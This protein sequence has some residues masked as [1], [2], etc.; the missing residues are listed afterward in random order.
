MAVFLISCDLRNPVF[1]YE[2]LYQALKAVKAEHIQNSVWRVNT[3]STAEIV[4]EYLWRH[5][6]SKRDRLFVVPFDKSQ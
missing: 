3:T 5:M 6:H 1:D 2:T 4:Y